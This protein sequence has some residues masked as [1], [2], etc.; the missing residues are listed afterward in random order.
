[1]V[2][3]HHIAKVKKPFIPHY[4]TEYNRLDEEHFSVSYKTSYKRRIHC[5]VCGMNEK[6]K[7]D[8]A[9][10]DSGYIC[11]EYDIVTE[12]EILKIVEASELRNDESKCEIEYIK[13]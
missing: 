5:P 6:H 12:S 2:N 1:M 10:Y 13:S 4:W 11:G 9:V 3:I 8:D 7:S